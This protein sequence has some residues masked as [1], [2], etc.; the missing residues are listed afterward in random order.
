[1]STETDYTRRAREHAPHTPQELSI[2][3]QD[4]TGRGYGDYDIARILELDINA[5]RRLI[6]MPADTGAR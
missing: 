5:T 4:L 3:A 1:M 6:G 2:A